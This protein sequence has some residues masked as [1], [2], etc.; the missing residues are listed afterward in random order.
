[1][2]L[3]YSLLQL[4]FKAQIGMPSYLYDITYNNGA[5]TLYLNSILVFYLSG[6]SIACL[7]SIRFQYTCLGQLV[8]LAF[9]YR[10]YCRAIILTSQ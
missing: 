3:Y 9:C 1:M 4:P 7:L 10:I 6:F 2:T 8:F 5:A